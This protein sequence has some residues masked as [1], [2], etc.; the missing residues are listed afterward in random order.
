VDKAKPI[1]YALPTL[2][3]RK[4]NERMTHS[5]SILGKKMIV[6]HIGLALQAHTLTFFFMDHVCKSGLIGSRV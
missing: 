6:M 1:G 4:K 3:K 2:F 5:L